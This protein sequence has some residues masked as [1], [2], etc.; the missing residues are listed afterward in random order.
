MEERVLKDHKV[1]LA[2]Q[3][4]LVAH[5]VV[6]VSR[7]LRAQQAQQARPVIKVSMEPQ[8]QRGPPVLSVLLDQPDH[9]VLVGL[10]LQV[11]QVQLDPRAHREVPV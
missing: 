4:R 9:K 6:P 3:D 10:D 1:A 7:G 11:Q 2:S 8:V 5:K